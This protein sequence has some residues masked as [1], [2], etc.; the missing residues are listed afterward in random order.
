M[1]HSMAYYTEDGP[2]VEYSEVRIT[3]Y[4]PQERKY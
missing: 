3:K 2:K 1:K 4:Q